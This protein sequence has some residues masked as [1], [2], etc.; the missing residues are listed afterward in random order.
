MLLLSH[1]VGHV[2]KVS[3]AC[4]SARVV[5]STN[6]HFY[7]SLFTI[8]LPE[9]TLAAFKDAISAGADII[10]LDVH[11]SKDNKIVVHHDESLSRMTNG[12]C[13]KLIAETNY[14]ELPPLQPTGAQ[15]NRCKGSQLV[16]DW[17]RIPLLEDVLN[18][19][20]P[21]CGVIIEIKEDSDLLIDMVHTAITT[22]PICS[23]KNV[24]WF[25]LVES[26]NSKLR[27]K[28]A[29]IPT[30]NSIVGMLRTLLF[31]YTGLLPFVDIPDAAFGVTV[32]EVC[33]LCIYIYIC[34]VFVLFVRGS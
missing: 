2:K 9:N 34:I 6:L 10:E 33:R 21:K 3:S 12:E 5:T 23:R 14:A 25:S 20:P 24:Y 32:E 22:H 17:Q 27:A 26:I 11:L 4:S 31:Y 15:S 29:T 28:D 7:S 19:V 13:G 18:I 8:G 16:S 1:I 30:I